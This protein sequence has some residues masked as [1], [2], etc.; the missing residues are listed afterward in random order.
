MEKAPMLAK[1][2]LTREIGSKNTNGLYAK[3]EEELL[4]DINKNGNWASGA[5]RQSYSVGCAY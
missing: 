4:A 2:A 5:G 1:K 3:L